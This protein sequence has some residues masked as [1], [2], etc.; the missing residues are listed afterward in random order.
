MRVR[1]GGDLVGGVVGGCVVGMEGVGG[2]VLV[3]GEVGR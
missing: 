2:C 3:K 1:I